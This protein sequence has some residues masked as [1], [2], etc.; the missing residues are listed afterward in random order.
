MHGG[1]S[2][3]PFKPD[4]R[5]VTALAAKTGSTTTANIDGVTTTIQVARDLTVATGDVLFVARFGAQWFATARA[6]SSAVTMPEDNDPPPDPKPSV[7]TGTLTVSPV[8]TC[9]W[10]GSAWRTDNDDVYQGAYGGGA[11]NTGAAFYGS[12]LTSLAGATVLSAS[13]QVRRL[14]R[15]LSWISQPTT[16]RLITET[17]RPAGAPTLDNS[18]AGPELR[19]D[20]TARFTIPDSWAQEMVD[21]TAG[22]IGFFDADG[23]PF[24]AFAGR[25]RWSPAFTMTINWSRST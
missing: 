4:S 23:T 10:N 13:I 5:L 14:P 2:Y 19:I 15:G 3:T 17:T 6:F 8:E 1:Q 11:N 25:G 24:V 21:G 22:G 7:V 18:S 12:K 16:M 20:E 9:T